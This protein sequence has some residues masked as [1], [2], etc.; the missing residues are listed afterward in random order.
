MNPTRPDQ[1]TILSG[2]KSKQLKPIFQ[3]D[4]ENIDLCSESLCSIRLPNLDLV[5]CARPKR[6]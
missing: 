1:E 2:C 4:L 6:K 5:V 3:S